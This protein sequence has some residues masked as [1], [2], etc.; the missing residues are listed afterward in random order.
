MSKPTQQQLEDIKAAQKIYEEK[1]LNKVILILY[2]DIPNKNLKKL[3]VD[4]LKTFKIV[5]FEVNFEK[6]NFMHLVG[7]KRKSIKMPLEIFYNNI[8]KNKVLLNDFELSEYSNK[9]NSVFPNLPTALRT[10]GT[11]GDYNY[12]KPYIEADK[13]IGS[14]KKM[15]TAVLG[16]R[17]KFTKSSNL[18][19]KRFAPVSLLE[20]I[21]ENLIKKDTQRKILV[22]LE[23]TVNEK[24][25]NKLSYKNK[26]YPIENLYNN[27]DFYKLLSFELQ[28]K[29][30]FEITGKEKEEVKKEINKEQEK[31]KVNDVEKKTKLEKEKPKREKRSRI[32][33]RVNER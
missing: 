21:T 5:G 9:K 24:Y 27:K 18:L 13:I 29:I 11:V 22:I 20:E 6:E 32:R 16:V 19:I 3:T 17:E 12:S 4:K 14:T 25:Y 15:N 31:N 33:S 26:D 7:I 2:A 30:L 1:L 10:V 23:K 28:E 8:K